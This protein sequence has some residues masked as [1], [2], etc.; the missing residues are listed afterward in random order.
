MSPMPVQISRYQQISTLS[1]QMV[2]AARA[3]DWDNLVVLERA[4]VVLRDAL[5]TDDDNGALSEQD[6]ELKAQLIQRILDN[7]AEVR[8]HTEPWME[9]LRQFLGGA[10]KRRQV[11]R[12][13]G[14]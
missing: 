1:T 5:M 8:R 10:S 11:E 6:L 3:G 4:V 7:D 13:Y 2:E 12:A 9:H 14:A